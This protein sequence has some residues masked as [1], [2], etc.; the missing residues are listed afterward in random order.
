MELT[1]IEQGKSYLRKNFKHGANCPCCG[2]TVKLYKRK[3][4]SGMATTLLWLY[5][6]SKKNNKE[7]V[8]I[9][10]VAP[11]STLR[12][13][14]FCILEYWDL[15]ERFPTIEP[16][17][18]YSG[19]WRITEKGKNFANGQEKVRSHVLIFNNKFV[20]YSPTMI[21]IEEALGEKFNYNEL[22]KAV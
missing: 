12:A 22:M 10:E 20:G 11:R 4:N 15:I 21:T 13:K 19:V 9:P 18:K 14:D 6:Y 1:T 16:G 7:W 2:Q 3:L 5:E 17:K 8:N